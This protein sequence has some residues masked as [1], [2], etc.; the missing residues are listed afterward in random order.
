[1][2]REEVPKGK[3]EENVL[4]NMHQLQEVGEYRFGDTIE[5]LMT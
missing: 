3:E 2:R 4:Q 1:M 5:W